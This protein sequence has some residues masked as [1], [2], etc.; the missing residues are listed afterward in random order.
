MYKPV[1]IIGVIGAGSADEQALDNAYRVGAAIA[2]S[3]AALVCGGM[4]G[5]MEAACRGAKEAGGLTIGIVPGPDRLMVNRYVDVP[6]VTN[7]GHARNVII[8]HTAQALIAVAGGP[9]TLSEIAIG[10]KLG[11]PV[12]SVNSWDVHD[13]IRRTDDPE[14]AVKWALEAIG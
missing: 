8:A 10:L 2:D 3:D 13:S 4:G 6:I 1:K 12:I 9:G 5:V 11:K 7:M 14:L